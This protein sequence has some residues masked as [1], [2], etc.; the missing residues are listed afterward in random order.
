MSQTIV[1]RERCVLCEKVVARLE[2]HD[3]CEQCVTNAEHLAADALYHL[4][5]VVN[6]LVT[7]LTPAEVLNAVRMSIDRA[8]GPL[9][10]TLLGRYEANTPLSGGFGFF[11][12]RP[13][14]STVMMTRCGGA[15]PKPLG[16]K[17]P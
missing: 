2:E 11:L 3:R 1:S 13:C 7:Q 4:E 9:T 6:D 14:S 10:G 12:S 15:P 17:A 5:F 8:E 16:T